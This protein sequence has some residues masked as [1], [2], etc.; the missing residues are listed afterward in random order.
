MSDRGSPMGQALAEEHL[1]K[2]ERAFGKITDAPPTL[3]DRRDSCW[4]VGFAAAIRLV[5]RQF[6]E[7]GV[8]TSARSNTAPLL[9]PTDWR[10]Y[11][12]GPFELKP[13]WIY[14]DQAPNPKSENWG[15]CMV[16]LL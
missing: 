7:L 1:G 8:A 5:R 16:N 11:I 3:P 12:D 9:K 15:P 14:V 13:R 2:I 4:S 10:C 6:G